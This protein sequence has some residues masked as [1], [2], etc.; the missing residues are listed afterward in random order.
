MFLG[1]GE[2]PGDSGH[3]GFTAWPG[4]VP[5]LAH[6]SLSPSRKAF[7]VGGGE[8]GSGRCLRTR[9]GRQCNKA[10]IVTGVRDPT[11]PVA[12][13]PCSPRAALVMAGCNGHR[14]GSENKVFFSVAL[15]TEIPFFNIS[16]FGF[17]VSY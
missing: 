14:E 12:D 5:L 3:Y 17:N 4:T 1:P 6:P 11:P 7:Y 2:N 8:D 15:Y 9:R 13:N 10:S 16:T